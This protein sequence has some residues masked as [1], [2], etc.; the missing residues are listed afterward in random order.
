MARAENWPVSKSAHITVGDPESQVAIGTL[1]TERHNILKCLDPKD[2]AIAGQLYMRTGVSYVV[3]NLL[4]NKYIRHLIVCGV[5]L[6]Q[7]GETLVQLWQQGVDSDYQVVGMEKAPIQKE[8]PVKA[9]DR[10]R[11]NV[12]LHD[13]RSVPHG[14][15]GE[16]VRNL[17]A[18]LPQLQP[19]GAPEVFRKPKVTIPDRLPSEGGAHIVRGKTIGETWLRMVREIMTYG[20]D[21]R[22]NYGNMAR[23]LSNLAAVVTDEDSENPNI[24]EYFSFTP[25][26]VEHYKEEFL[27]SECPP[28]VSYTYGQRIYAFGPN[29]VNQAE[30]MIKKLQNDPNDRGAVAIL[31]DPWHDNQLDVEVPLEKGF[32]NPCL[33]LIQS[34]I[35][36]G[37][38]ELT[39]FFRSNDMFNGWPENA[40]G[41]RAFQGWMAKRLGRPVG[42][43][44]TVSMRAHI[45]EEP[46]EQVGN[47]LNKYSA[48]L[49]S[50]I[51][52]PRG[53]LLIEL[54]PELG[55]ISVTHQDSLGQQLHKTK[56]FDG[57][58]SGA[59]VQAER[60][61]AEGDFISSAQHGLYLGRE[62]LMAELAAK[63]RLPYH[64]S[65]GN[66]MIKSIEEMAR[67]AQ[68]YDR[69]KAEGKI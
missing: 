11:Q 35:K 33:V 13:L 62:F 63:L 45:Y 27:S 57:R 16:A 49:H 39:G 60:W 5:D 52:D 12:E 53:N 15:E 43:L 34:T 9:I 26:D 4:S 1:W 28:G 47:I 67:K 36:D 46:W 54:N 32:R 29:K 14:H 41:L 8:I 42:S 10:L 69:L 50:E 55:K 58:K 6:S 2:Y 61:V 66:S 17:I 56:T 24:A 64:Q 37:K 25:K 38:L 51:A 18:D 68:E 7:T 40:V 44:T 31:Y 23:D 20:A 22:T 3:R 48:N 65:K 19:W 59:S 21:D 30:I